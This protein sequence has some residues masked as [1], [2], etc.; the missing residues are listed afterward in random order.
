MRSDGVRGAGDETEVRL[1]VFIERSGDADDDGVH[2]G[3]LGVVA[4][5]GKALGLRGPDFFRRDAVDVRATL[6]Q[7]FHFSRVDIESRD[8]KLLLAVKQ[9]EGQTDIA[10]ADDSYPDLALLD[11]GLELIKNS[12]C[13]RVGTHEGFRRSGKSRMKSA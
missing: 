9:G 4:S 6:A 3:D 2:F 7:G 5:R 1:V 10:Q 12:I 13:S 8:L 11:F